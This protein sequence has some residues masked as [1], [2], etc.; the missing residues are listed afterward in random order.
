MSMF[1][2]LYVFVTFQV[3]KEDHAI[4]SWIFSTSNYAKI[5]E[6]HMGGNQIYVPNYGTFQ[7]LWHLAGDLKTLKC[8]YN[9]SHGANTKHPCLYCMK[10]CKDLNLTRSRVGPTRDREDP[11][12]RPVLAIPLTNVHI[13]TLHAEVR[14]IEKLIFNHIL[15]VWNTKPESASKIGIERLEQVLSKAGLHK[16]NVKIKKSEKLSGKS[17]N[18][19]NKPSVGGAKARRFLSNHTGKSSTVTYNVW[20]DVV[21]ASKDFEEKGNTRLKKAAV[22]QNLDNLIG[23]LRKEKL[24]EIDIANLQKYCEIFVKSVAECWGENHVTHYMVIHYLFLCKNCSATS[25]I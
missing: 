12:F 25:Y 24:S 22:W 23:M 15:Y 3:L 5:I 17:G 11:N 16:G 6:E 19:P 8:M 18:V 9:V 14:I 20:K 10:N 21:A 4:L 1:V 7:I 13:C 2:T